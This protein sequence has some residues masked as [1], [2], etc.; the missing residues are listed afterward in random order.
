MYLSIL[1]KPTDKELVKFPS[2]NLTNIHEWDSSVLH[3]TYPEG[4]GEPVWAYDPKHL[5]L[6]DPN[7]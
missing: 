4:D 1:R 7:F 6:L 3:F 2:V 5:D